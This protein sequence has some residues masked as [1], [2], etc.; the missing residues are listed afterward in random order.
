MNSMYYPILTVTN[1][2]HEDLTVFGL[3][4]HEKPALHTPAGDPVLYG[5]VGEDSDGQLLVAHGK[6]RD[7]VKAMRST[8]EAAEEKLITDRE[9]W[10]LVEDPVRR[11]PRRFWDMEDEEFYGAATTGRTIWFY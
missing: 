4:I 2:K 3:T 5:P 1:R 7:P 11:R 6:Y 9:R 8:I 10:T